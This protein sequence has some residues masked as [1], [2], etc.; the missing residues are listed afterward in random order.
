MNEENV[1][2]IVEDMNSV[3]DSHDFIK[4][5]IWR[6]PTIYG[7]MLVKYD[8]VR[9]THSQIGIFLLNHA[10][11]LKIEKTGEDGS[12]DIFGHVTPCAKW[13]KQ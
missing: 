9:T 11:A 12:D 7:E 3:F 1:K 4:E 2:A 13:K 10:D 8:N 6:Y 5:F